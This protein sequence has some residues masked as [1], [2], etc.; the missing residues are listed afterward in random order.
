[1]EA[2]KALA[3]AE[4]R[5]DTIVVKVSGVWQLTAEFPEAAQVL[6]KRRGFREV[7]VV[8]KDLT[9][10]DS[11][12]PL[13]LMQ[14]HAWCR[15]Q[16]VELNLEAL[17]GK[18]RSLYDL[19]KE[20]EERGAPPRAPEEVQDLVIETSRRAFAGLKSSVS[21]IGE[22]ALGTLAIPAAPRRVRWKDLYME[23]VEAGPRAL[24]IVGLLSFLFGVVFAYETISQ[25]IHFG[26]Q[27]FITSAMGLAL[28]RQV[29]PVLSAIILAGRTGAAFAA[30]LGNM[31]L[32]GEL[33][34]LEVLGISPI[35]YLVLP[36]LAALLLMLPTIALYADLFGF[37]GGLTV[38]HIEMNM[39]PSEYW[40]QV[41]NSLSLEDLV[42]GSIKAAVFGAAIGLAGTLRGLQCERSSAG[43]GRAATSAVVTGITW[44][45]IADA[46]FAF[47]L[48]QF[49]A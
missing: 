37:L 26:A 14:I 38:A 33:D 49:K 46:I 30:H 2:S 28:V 45:I 19:V 5:G 9:Q 41:K 20:S 36:R 1:M 15:E 6:G 48:A 4:E 12:L 21:F 3:E 39:P 29:G 22:C 11:S 40:I 43:V 47:V 17:P 44:L 18:L 34:A 42:V 35:T 24:P 8:P 27:A 25:L 31:K 7:R 13:F 16:G 23:L 10:W 32:G